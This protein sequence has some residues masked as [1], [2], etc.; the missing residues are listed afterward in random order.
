LNKHSKQQQQQ[1]NDIEK[2]HLTAPEKK[3]NKFNVSN[4]EMGL[5]FD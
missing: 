3:K 1:Q 2:I 5:L 4:E